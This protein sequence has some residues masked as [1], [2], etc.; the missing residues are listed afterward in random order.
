[1]IRH[2]HGRRRRCA[3]S[4]LRHWARLRL[5]SLPL[6]ALMALIAW[7]TF[8]TPYTTRYD[9]PP[10]RSDGVG[11]HAWTRALLTGDLSFCA[12][13][14]AIENF[15]SSYDK[16]RKFCQNKYPP[17]LA[18]LRLPVMAF[19]ID[20][21]AK[22]HRIG[23]AEHRASLVLGG[24]F[25]CLQCWLLFRVAALLQLRFW[26]SAAAITLSVIGT[27]LLHYGTYDSAFTHAYS[28][29]FCALL[30][31]L[32]VR[33]HATAR[34]MSGGL[35][36]LSAFFMLALRMTNIFLLVIV[37][38]AYVV[39]R[40]HKDARTLW[41]NLASVALGA[42]AAIG[43]QLAYNYL[44]NGSLGANSYGEEGFVWDRPMQ[45][46]VLFS[47]E[48]G[49]FTYF[50]L[51]GVAILSGCYV[52]GARR[53][54]WL[55][56]SLVAA[57]TLLYGFWHSWML[58]DGMGHRGFVELGP[59]VAVLLC[60]AWQRLHGKQLVAAVCAGTLAT[61]VTLQIMLGYWDTSFPT[62]GATR[63]DY[64]H[65]LGKLPWSHATNS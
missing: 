30:V 10:I 45:P 46:S 3:A 64:W 17:G 9:G 33:E 23:P 43:M 50:P 18:L 11:Y 58:G 65:Q 60:C 41:R 39:W 29:F 36:A 34:P 40:P 59:I 42:G 16:Q 22:P 6:A 32:A 26:R 54:C 8:A 20:T 4:G 19:L 53:L 61:A 35:L 28:A 24:A 49:L 51:F 56:V 62:L 48:R 21:S 27:G 25:L 47:Y 57:Y 13:R 55:L 44:A 37:T 31:Y 12:W 38:L 52:R 63:E 5:R 7:V 2:L 15:V 14:G 1:V